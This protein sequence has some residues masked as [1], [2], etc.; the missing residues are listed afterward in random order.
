MKAGAL[1]HLTGNFTRLHHRRIHRQEFRALKCPDG[2]KLKL[3]PLTVSAAGTGLPCTFKLPPDA[4]REC[5]HAAFYVQRPSGA[6]YGIE[7]TRH[8][9][10]YLHAHRIEGEDALRWLG[11]PP[12]ALEAA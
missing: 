2:H 6:L 5:T 11:V 1:P 10:L 9:L 8:E 12:E 3:Q 4:R 7:A